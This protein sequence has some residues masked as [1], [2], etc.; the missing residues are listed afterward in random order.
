MEVMT[1]IRTFDILYYI[2]ANNVYSIAF[3]FDG[4]MIFQED[5]VTKLEMTHPEVMS[6]VTHFYQ[7]TSVNSAVT[8]NVMKI[9]VFYEFLGYTTYAQ[10][11][12][13]SDEQFVSDLGMM[14]CGHTSFCKKNFWSCKHDYLIPV[15]KG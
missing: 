3:H 14:F 10:Q 13:Y 15:V 7:N 9:N 1:L 8:S 4:C 11:V 6:K 2:T 5:F 12:S